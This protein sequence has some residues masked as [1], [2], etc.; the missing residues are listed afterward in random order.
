MAA[1]CWMLGLGVV[2]WA[3]CVFHEAVLPKGKW[4]ICCSPGWA[5]GVFFS[6]GDNSPVG[7]VRASQC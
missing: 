2:G 4:Q 3:Q 1:R 7:K 6:S 5:S